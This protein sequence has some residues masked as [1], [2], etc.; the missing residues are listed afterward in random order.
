MFPSW[1]IQYTHL[2]V[3]SSG[4]SNDRQLV[5]NFGRLRQVAEDT[6][7]SLKNLKHGTGK[8]EVADA[9]FAYQPSDAFT[10]SEPYNHHGVVGN[11]GS[12]ERKRYPTVSISHLRRLETRQSQSMALLLPATLPHPP[13]RT[14]RMCLHLL[15][16]VGN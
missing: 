15:S 10:R 13:R 12:L 4:S 11:V 2:S 5:S 1:F 6:D 7:R 14:I 16:D 9:G 3:V 8:L